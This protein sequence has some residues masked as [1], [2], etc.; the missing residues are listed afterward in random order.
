MTQTIAKTPTVTGVIEGSVYWITLNQPEKRNAISLET[1]LE[2]PRMIREAEADPQVRAVVIRGSGDEAF[3]AGADISEFPE[4]RFEPSKGL[5]YN[6][7]HNAGEAAILE[8]RK[9][10]VA[11]VDGWCVGGGLQVAMACDM[12]LGTSRSRFGIT[13]ARLGIV[14]SHQSTTRLETEI[15][16][17]W[18]K[19]LLFTGRIISAEEA[20]RINIIQDTG[21]EEYIEQQLDR[22][23]SEIIGGEPLAQFATKQFSLR[24][25]RTYTEDVPERQL[26]QESFSNERYHQ[27][28]KSFLNKEK[29]DFSAYPSHLGK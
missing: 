11:L 15:G 8:C 13:P 27:A 22:L 7:A 6:D 1:W 20:L 19:L 3:S 14:I 24:N 18:T 16:P 23:L 26:V 4:N 17:A 5:D 10:T 28:V 21:S 2:F 29:T 25:I 9:P 12:R